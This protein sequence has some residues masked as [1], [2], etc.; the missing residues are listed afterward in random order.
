MCL[1]ETSEKLASK[2][3]HRRQCASWT[4]SVKSPGSSRAEINF[5]RQKF[6]FIALAV[7]RRAAPNQ[8]WIKESRRA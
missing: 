4:S 2:K 3:K 8:V 1:D 6:I 5:R 7:S